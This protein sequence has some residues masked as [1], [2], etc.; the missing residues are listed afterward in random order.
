MDVG[1]VLT[2]CLGNFG[3]WCGGV[4]MADWMA[5][6]HYHLQGSEFLQGHGRPF[7]YFRYGVR[8]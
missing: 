5:R 3:L 4:I 2:G 8:P 7:I 6:I 1:L